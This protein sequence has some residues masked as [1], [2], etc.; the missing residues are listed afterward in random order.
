MS[1][2]GFYV[3]EAKTSISWRT[4]DS[5]FVGTKFPESEKDGL[6]DSGYARIVKEWKR[7]TPLS[8]A[9]LIFE[10]NQTDVSVHGS[11]DTWIYDEQTR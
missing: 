7:G 5:V 9:M 11:R 10:G 2:G 4:R 6:T 3:P 8:E 1:S